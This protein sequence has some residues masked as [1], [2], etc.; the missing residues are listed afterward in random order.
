LFSGFKYFRLSK[1]G[2]KSVLILLLYSNCAFAQNHHFIYYG[3]KEGLAHSQVTN[4][5]CD[6]TGNLYFST[7]GGGVSVFN[8]KTFK[9]YHK[10]NGLKHMSVRACSYG[11]GKKI[12]VGT[13]T[14]GL[15][16][17]E[18]D[19]AV[20]VN[21]T[22]FKSDVFALA[23]LQGKLWIGT[24]VGLFTWDGNAFE[25][26]TTKF[27]LPE[28]AVTFLNSDS[29]G[30]IWF[31]YDEQYGLYR[32]NG[33]QL[34]NF[35]AKNGLTDA[36]ILNCFHDS[37][38]TTWVAS[39]DGVYRISKG[40]NTAEKEKAEGLPSYYAFDFVEQG[41]ELIISS[42]LGL[43]FYDPEKRKVRYIISD[44]NG[45][46]AKGV[47]RIIQDKEKNIWISNWGN[48]VA[49]FVQSG[50]LKYDTRN[51]FDTKIINGFYETE[52][53][54]FVT[55]RKGIF[56][57]DGNMFKSVV[58]D[59]P[60]DIVKTF[61]NS[62]NDFWILYPNYIS[63]V[64]N[65]KATD[66][67]GDSVSGARQAV[68]DSKGDL[69]FAGW[70]CGVFK[71]VNGKYVA[72][73]DSLPRT[74]IYYYT[75][76][77]DSKDR[78]WLGS[79]GAGLVRFD[80][81]NWKRFTEADGLQSER[82]TALAEDEN[83]FIYAGSPDAGLTMI[84]PDDK[85]N[86]VEEGLAKPLNSIN[87]LAYHKGYL[88]LGGVSK[89]Q[90][91]KLDNGKVIEEE[92]WGEEEGFTADCMNDGFCF[93]RNNRLLIATN[94]YLYAFDETYRHAAGDRLQVIIEELK[95]KDEP[96]S[97]TGEFLELPYN[98]NRLAFTC[99]GN[100]MERNQEVNYFYRM[101]G[102]DTNFIPVTVENDIVFHELQPGDYT[103]EIKAFKREKW[104]SVS[105]FHFRILPPFWRTWWFYLLIFVS[106]IAFIAFYIRI[107]ERKLKSD[108]IRLEQIVKIRTKEIND[109]KSLIETKQKEILDSIHYAQRI[110]K[111]LLPNEKI[112]QKLIKKKKV[113]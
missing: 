82:I 19:S 15:Y 104:S 92:N 54:L 32:L 13:F 31:G 64:V 65:G 103:F 25:N 35:S 8:G 17:L 9:T 48:G 94:A 50:L 84:A 52:T 12:Y 74:H 100:R 41:N 34:T 11:P 10:K 89:I 97:F 102:L 22:I 47:F 83:G 57:K 4:L 45:L 36:R 88:W 18:K 30:N 93:D 46:A 110:Q 49:R 38:N 6:S 7:M 56:K 1:F 96:V 61:F 108:K 58:P 51:G 72:V 23:Y 73:K 39:S 69:W 60:T 62:E 3:I 26:L 87:T 21:D 70:G 77:R 78:I 20:L 24:G 27:E 79:S 55:G 101:L 109:Q 107:R 81:K 106:L 66:I 43:H 37:K 42:N 113:D 14:G 86:V 105:S 68:R 28:Y 80:G 98:K 67:K 111:A 5:F 85:I 53:N 63:R 76:F 40:A 44:Q 75:V 2:L 71:I 90:R 33:S 29:Q 99:Y 112:I 59:I 16:K 91:I 95:I